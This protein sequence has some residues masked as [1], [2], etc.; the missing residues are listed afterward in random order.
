MIWKRSAN[1]IHSSVRSVLLCCSSDKE[2]Q[3]LSL[4]TAAPKRIVGRSGWRGDVEA[5][6]ASCSPKRCFS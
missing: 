2:L 4:T 5:L 1:A 6:G 3:N